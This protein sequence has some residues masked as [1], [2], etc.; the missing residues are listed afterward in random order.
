VRRLLGVPALVGPPV[1]AEAV[2]AAGRRDELPG[3]AA[4]ATE[5]A[6]GEN[7]LRSARRRRGPREGLPGEDLL[8]HPDILPRA[9]QVQFEPLPSLG[10][11]VEDELVDRLVIPEKTP[12]LPFA[13]SSE[14][15]VKN[16][17][18]SLRIFRNVLEVFRHLK[19]D[20]AGGENRSG[21]FSK[22]VRRKRPLGLS[23]AGPE[24]RA[25]RETPG[26]ERFSA[27]GGGT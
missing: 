8:H 4:F 1:D 26:V 23:G 16:L 5:Y 11:E 22:E 9:G 24:R 20:L 14:A 3:P 19:V 6:L 15:V 17:P 7:P 2:P 21:T 25:R 12:P 13:T 10:L 18:Q 27:G